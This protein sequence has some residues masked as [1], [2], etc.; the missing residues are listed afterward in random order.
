MGG[1]PPRP[2]FIS[3]SLE[4]FAEENGMEIRFSQP[5]KLPQNG[6]VERKET[7]A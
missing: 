2:E 6:L 3:R 5:G 1:P 7:N 4:R